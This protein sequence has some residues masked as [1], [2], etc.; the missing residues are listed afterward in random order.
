MVVT[1]SPGAQPASEVVETRCSLIG[2]ELALALALALE[3]TT[4]LVPVELAAMDEAELPMGV[5]L[6]YNAIALVPPQSWLGDP[7]VA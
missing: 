7:C 6:W 2:M 1:V 5:L 4:V 3:L